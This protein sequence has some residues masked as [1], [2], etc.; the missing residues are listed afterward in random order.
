M[1]F[2]NNLR[3]TIS[4]AIAALVCAVM[5]LGVASP[6]FAFGSDTS[7]PREG[8]PQMNDMVETSRQ[9]VKEEPRNPE[10]IQ[11]KAN[12]GPNGVQ[13]AANLEKMNN[14]ANSQEARTVRDQAEDLLESITPGN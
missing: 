12:R 10:E 6:A 8:V 11:R 1:R 4:A 7:S 2:F 9:S 3:R 14:P 13:G 5:L